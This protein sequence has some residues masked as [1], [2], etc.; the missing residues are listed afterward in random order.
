MTPQ[1]KEAFSASHVNH[2]RTL[3]ADTQSSIDAAA[4]DEQEGISAAARDA[5]ERNNAAARDAME[6]NNVVATKAMERHIAAVKET[7]GRLGAFEVLLHVHASFFH[8]TPQE[9]D[10]LL[11]GEQGEQSWNLQ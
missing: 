9:K 1:E 6:R 4:S 11:A 3:L 2:V 8:L 7:M 5:M 10:A